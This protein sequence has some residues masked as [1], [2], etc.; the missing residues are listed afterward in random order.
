MAEDD[1]SW[2]FPESMVDVAADGEEALK[3][4]SLAYYDLVV[5][6]V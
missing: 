2:Y 5:I 4:Y 1:L 6:D 3:M